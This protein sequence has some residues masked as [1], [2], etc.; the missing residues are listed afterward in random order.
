ML[1]F[2]CGGNTRANKKKIRAM[3]F[4]YL[5]LKPKKRSV[6]NRFLA[7]LKKGEKQKIVSSD[8]EYSCVKV[9][10]GEEINYIYYSEKLK[11]NQLRKKAKKFKAGKAGAT[12]RRAAG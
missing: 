5:T 3:G 7:L 10:D 12:S 1:I 8:T 2:D 11:K 6:Y 9:V 4:H